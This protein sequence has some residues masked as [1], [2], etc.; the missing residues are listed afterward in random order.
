MKPGY[1]VRS[2]KGRDVAPCVGA[3]IETG[4]MEAYCDITPVAPCVGAWIETLSI[5]ANNATYTKSLPAWE[6]GL[7]P[8]RVRHPGHD[9]RGRSLRGSVD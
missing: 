2:C 6:R 4:D 9:V 7:K 1:D 3:W 8:D 5:T